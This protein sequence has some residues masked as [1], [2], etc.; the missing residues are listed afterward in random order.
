MFTFN[1][2]CSKTKVFHQLLNFFRFLIPK[3]SVKKLYLNELSENNQTKYIFYG[4]ENI[5]LNNL[6]NLSLEKIKV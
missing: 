5:K 2:E 3:K 6:I 1:Y 4:I